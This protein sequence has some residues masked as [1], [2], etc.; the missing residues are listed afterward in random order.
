M[1]AAGFPGRPA[2]CGPDWVRDAVF[3]QIFP[4]RFASSVRVPKPGTL[5]RWDAPPTLHGFKG[6]DLL[7][8]AE[9]L[10]DLRELGITALYL[11]PVFASA[12]NHR[13]HTFDYER[14]DPLLGGDEALRELIDAAHDRGM[15]IILDGVFNH[16]SRGFWPFHHVLE[17]GA[18][19]PYRDWFYLDREVLSGR[20][21][22]TAYPGANEIEAIRRFPSDDESTGTAG[23]PTGPELVHPATP[24][25][26]VLGY[27][28]WWDL[29][30]LPK[31]NHSNP[32]VREYVYGVVERWTRFGIDGWRL[33]VPEEI[34]E[35]GFWEE[36]RSRVL[37]IDTE[38]Y[39]V[40]EIWNP[41]PDW[42]AGDRFHALMNYPLTEAI[43]SF[44]G[45]GRL[46]EELVSKTHEYSRHVRAID[47]PEFVRELA[48]VMATYPPE[49]TSLQLN[50]LDSH[51]TPRFI[52]LAGGDATALRLAVLIQMTLPGAPC[53]YYG[54][55]VGL[56]GREDPDCRRG[57]PWDVARQDRAMRDF[58]AGLTALRHAN[59]VL[60]R[61]RFEPLAAEGSA[62][63]YGM[64]DREDPAGRSIVVAMNA[65][66]GPAR[67]NFE[68]PGL[69]GRLAQQV[70]WP[71]R[72][73]S[74]AFAS[75]LLETGALEVELEAREGVVIEAVP[76][77]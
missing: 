3:Y 51:D 12:S 60:R 73:W 13:Y 61:G 49:V 39:L 37:A 68:H 28:A 48:E 7:G 46:D 27:Q 38:S 57:Y 56:E 36:F 64:F 54:D 34:G 5:E 2:A 67:L 26:R 10:D 59:P 16:A 77:L 35:P 18:A 25:E 58:V 31:L 53:I 6:G 21:G 65:G 43:L 24:S 30:A 33:D 41:A 72:G 8:I 74:T 22:L 44:T 76:N 63:A 4:D 75:R 47:G 66:G 42:L 32:A 14:V 11:N 40:G 45:A 62:V 20:R 23:D 69:A 17:N 9:H 1:N 55:E 50:L 19:S 29:P 71:G 52:S 70:S 15:R